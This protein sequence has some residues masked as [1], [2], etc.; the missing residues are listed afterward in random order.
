MKRNNEYR[1]LPALRKF[2]EDLS[3]NTLANMNY[4]K[5]VQI[6][7]ADLLHKHNNRTI[8]LNEDDYNTVI[9]LLDFESKLSH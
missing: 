5:K 6:V 2:K 7:S 8:S 1:I 4:L 9:Y 3:A